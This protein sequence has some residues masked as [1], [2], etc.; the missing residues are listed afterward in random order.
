MTQAVLKRYEKKYMV[1]PAQYNE[2][3]SRMITRIEADQYGKHMVCDVYF[4]TPD[5][6]MIR[7]SLSKPV[8]QENLRLRSYGRCT[9]EKTVFLELKKKYDGAVYK[10]RV[11][12]KLREARKYLY[13]GIEPDVAGVEGRAWREVEQAVEFYNPC[14][15]VYLAYERIAF[16]GKEDPGLRITFD[17]NM[18][19]RFFG[20]DLGKRTYGVPLAERGQIMMEIKMAGAMPMWLVR[21]LSELKICHVSLSKYG[22]YYQKYLMHGSVKDTC[23]KKWKEM[24]IREEGEL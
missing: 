14:P 11:P 21:L 8:Y 6:L 17:M 18:R 16:S 2:L 15:A 22:M 13:C 4:D 7:N 23:N 9:E 19:A 5:Y 20:M 12:M 24:R 10:C 1:S 3:I